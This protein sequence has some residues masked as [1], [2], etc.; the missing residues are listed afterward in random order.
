MG[1]NGNGWKANPGRGPNAGRGPAGGGWFRVAA[2]VLSVGV[3]GLC[4]ADKPRELVSLPQGSA[5]VAFSPD[6]KTVATQ[7]DG[8]EIR[9]WDVATGKERASLEF[10]GPLAGAGALAFSPDGKLL[11]SGSC[12]AKVKLWD[13]ATGK[14]LE[15]VQ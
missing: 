15:S 11:A 2:V 6:G 12:Q 5:C 14:E 4:G 1:L 10:G 7:G 3:V 13:P 9:L 8:N